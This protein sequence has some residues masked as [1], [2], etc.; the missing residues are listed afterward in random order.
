MKQI[1]IKMKCYYYNLI[2]HYHTLQSIELHMSRLSRLDR[3]PTEIN[4]KLG[5]QISSTK[6]RVGLFR[7]KN[8]I[9]Q[10]RIYFKYFK[11]S[12]TAFLEAQAVV[13]MILE[14]RQKSRTNE[15]NGAQAV[16]T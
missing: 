1:V 15:L 10:F 7:T 11:L 4:Q 13:V 3:V 2:L 6:S 8:T 12:V 5:K 9:I 14:T 16:N